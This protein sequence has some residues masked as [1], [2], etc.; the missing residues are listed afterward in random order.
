MNYRMK[1]LT[2]STSPNRICTPWHWLFLWTFIWASPLFAQKQIPS[3]PTGLVADYPNVLSSAE[4]QALNAKLRAYEDSTSTQIA[5]VL[6]RSLEGEEIFDYSF[7]LA[8]AWGIGQQGR[9][10]GILLYVAFEDRQIFIQTGFGAE[11]FLPDAY[12]KR[13]IE[14][15]IKPAFRQGA[16]Y[17]GLDQATSYIMQAGAGEFE[18]LEQGQQEVKLDRTLGLLIRI[19]VIVVI[20][21][22][23]SRIGGG[24]GGNGYGGDGRYRRG[25]GGI[26]WMGPGMGGGGFGGGGGGG[27][28]GGG[29]WGG[30]GGGG[31]GGGGAGGSW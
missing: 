14:Q 25:G 16:Y 11:G 9:D 3:A 2:A 22:L 15:V 7:R 21:V 27:F 6:D 18:A 28:S 23:L 12:A 17:Q 19:I 4:V 1:F 5:V 13:I 24:G 10:N 31:F 8:E 20:I 26:W 29:S 30:F